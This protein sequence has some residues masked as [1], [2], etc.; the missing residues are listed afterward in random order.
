MKHLLLV[1]VSLKLWEQMV[2]QDAITAVKC[3][4]GI[5]GDAEMVNSF[6]DG[7]R[8]SV[9]FVYQHPTFPAIPEAS[10][11]PQFIP[12]FEMLE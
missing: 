5:P 1:P 10:V 11:I 3:I 9:V 6:Y 4:D 12:T 7:H 2:K 8:Q